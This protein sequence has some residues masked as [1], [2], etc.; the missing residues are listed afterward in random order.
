MKTYE[1][2]GVTGTAKEVVAKLHKGSRAPSKDDTTWMAECA[3]RVK[4]IGGPDIRHDTAEHFLD[5]VV[6]YNLL[7]DMK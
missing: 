1:I 3:H 6:S 5:D 2:H 4:V 7:E